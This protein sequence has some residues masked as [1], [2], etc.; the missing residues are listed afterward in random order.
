MIL[1]ITLGVVSLAVLGLVIYLVRRGDRRVDQLADARV[2][3]VATEGELERARYE[4]EIT[5][6]A[7]VA[8]NRTIR[9]LETVTDVNADPNPDL[10]R[11]DVRARVL[12]EALAW[13]DGGGALPADPT[14]ELPADDGPG[15]GPRAPDLRSATGP[16][17]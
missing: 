9:I 8:A 13:K 12:R 2:A 4:H 17:V 7:L 1:A 14:D 5:K 11:S 10:D 15:A 6:A 3:Q 16:D